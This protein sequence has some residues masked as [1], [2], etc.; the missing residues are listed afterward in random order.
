[1]TFPSKKEM[2]EYITLIEE[3]AKRDHRII[4][5]QQ[6]LFNHHQLSP[7]CGFW[8][9]HGSKIYNKLIELIRDEYRVRGY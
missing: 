4:G 6:G 1:V 8:Y 3:A 9:P 5:K 7:G 2:D